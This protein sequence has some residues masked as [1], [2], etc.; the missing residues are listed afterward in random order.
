MLIWKNLF[1]AHRIVDEKDQTNQTLEKLLFNV[2]C[3]AEVG[4]I[5]V[6]LNVKNFYCSRSYFAF[7]FPV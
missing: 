7:R 1:S 6:F 3:S 5:S 4:I 2:R